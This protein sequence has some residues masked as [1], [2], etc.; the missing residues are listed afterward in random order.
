MCLVARTL[1]AAGIPTV[2]VGSALDIVS[3]CGAPRHVFT[4]FPL[5]NPC[6][7]PYDVPMQR[8]IVGMAIDI[9]ETATGP[10]A[11][12]RTPFEWGSDE[13]RQR[14]M[15]IRPQD[16]QRLAAMG[17]ARRSQRQALRDTGRVRVE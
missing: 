13:W 1:E 2:I 9:L 5:G 12:Q 17:E 3:H 11:F 16:L 8:A 7:K 15:E 4:D 10:G 6:G 14:Y